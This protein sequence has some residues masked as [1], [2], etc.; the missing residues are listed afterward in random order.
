MSS[1]KLVNTVMCVALPGRE[2]IPHRCALTASH[3]WHCVLSLLLAL[4]LCLRCLRSCAG[5]VFLNTANATPQGTGNQAEKPCPRCSGRRVATVTDVVNVTIPAGTPHGTKI[6][7]R[8]GPQAIR[9]TDGTLTAVVTVLPHSKFKLLPDM[10]LMY[11][12]DISLIDALIGF[13]YVE[14]RAVDSPVVVCVH[15]R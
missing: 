13:T 9:H 14:I 3:C 15:H 8:G 11:T 10:H 1:T 4:L 5:F 6:R 2:R 12:T 7:L